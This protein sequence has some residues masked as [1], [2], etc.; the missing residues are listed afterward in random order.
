MKTGTDRKYT[1][2]F[3]ASAVKQVPV[4]TPA[5]SAGLTWLF[6]IAMEAQP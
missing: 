1:A 4:A 5:G 2:E 3:R 6:C